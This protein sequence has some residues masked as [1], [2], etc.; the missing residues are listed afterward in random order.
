MFLFVVQAWFHAADGDN[1]GAE[2]DN[3]HYGEDAGDDDRQ[4]HRPALLGH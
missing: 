1:Y 3:H 4:N 2:Y